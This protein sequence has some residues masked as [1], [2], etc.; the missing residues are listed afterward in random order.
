[1]T[2]RLHQPKLSV[3]VAC[4]SPPMRAHLRAMLNREPDLCL[5]GEADTGAAVLDLFFRYRPDVVLVDV[6]LPDRN[7]FKIVESIKQAVPSCRAILLCRI[8]DP[9]VEEVSRM[10]G[11][12]HI[13]QTAGELQ[14]VLTLLRELAVANNADGAAQSHRL[15]P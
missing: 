2:P 11:A 15:Q 10:V 6:C 13:C 3:L 8:A 12:N 4:S 14:P 9:C 7:G 1:V 5:C